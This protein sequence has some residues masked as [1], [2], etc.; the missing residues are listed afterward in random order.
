MMTEHPDYD[1]G[2]INGYGG[3]DVSWWQDYLR[4]E[5]GRANDHWRDYVAE[6]E[7][8]KAQ[9][10]DDFLLSIIADIRAKSGV[11]DRPM[12]TE[13]ADAIKAKISAKP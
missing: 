9:A 13:L 1:C 4:A 6:L 2:L 12:L 11:G 7:A 10:K 8:F 5:I 3:G